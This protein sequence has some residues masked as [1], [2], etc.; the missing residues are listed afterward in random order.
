MKSSSEFG[1]GRGKYVSIGKFPRE[2]VESPLK[3]FK[4]HLDVILGNVLHVTLLEEGR[5]E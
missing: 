5:L 3:I 2:V 4:T 1:R